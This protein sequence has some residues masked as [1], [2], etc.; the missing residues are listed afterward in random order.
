MRLGSLLALTACVALA[1][2]TGCAADSDD[3]ALDTTSSEIRTGGRVCSW[4]LRRLGHNFDTRPKDIATVAKII[5]QNC[6]VI[7]VQ[8]VMQTAGQPT[9]YTDLLAKLGSRW[10]GVITAKAQPDDPVKSS[11]EHYAYFYRRSAASIC[12]GF[13]AETGGVERLA[14]PQGTFLREPAWTC[15]TMKGHPRDVLLASYHAMFGSIAERRREIGALDDDLNNDGQKDDFLHAMQ[16]S[17]NGDADILMV[18][19]FNV[20]GDDLGREL[21]G[22]SERTTATTGSTLNLEDGISPNLYD[23][24]LV[25]PGQPQLDSLGAAEVL[26]VR[27]TATTDSFYR[28]VSD[29]L[30]IRFSLRGVS[31]ATTTTP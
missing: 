15:F 11:S 8:E 7:A 25:P 14:D 3:E 9:G 6:D 28:S 19:D 29:H 13:A 30:P 12:S 26:D 10:G 16:A 24:L 21:P 4:N 5:T 18:G 2:S 22:W 27:S 20:D 1:A 23:H 31:N 17:H